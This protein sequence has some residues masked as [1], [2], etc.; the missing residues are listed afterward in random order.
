M[1]INVSEALDSDT[2]VILTVERT[3]G[4][5]YVDGI[6]I[7]G[8]TTIFKTLG[9]PQQPTAQD[10]QILPEGERNKDIYKFIT[11]KPV[12]TASDKDSVIADTILFKGAR[13]KIIMVQDWDLFGHTTS[14]GARDQ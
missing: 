14:F 2:G 11:K 10:L 12:R 13:F 8:N 7:K 6:Y 3:T 4:G 1:P 9:S 5:G